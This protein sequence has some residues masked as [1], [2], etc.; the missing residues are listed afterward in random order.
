MARRIAS[1]LAFLFAGLLAVFAQGLLDASP[2]EAPDPRAFGV[3]AGALALFLW[4]LRQEP[5]WLEGGTS[6]R[7]NSQPLAFRSPL[8][9]CPEPG[10]GR[11]GFP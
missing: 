3:Y 7:L 11:A 8:L 5:A 10:A 1:A 9:G 6:Q 4:A 2:R